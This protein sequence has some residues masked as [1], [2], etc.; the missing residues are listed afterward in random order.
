MSIGELRLLT[1]LEISALL[2]VPCG[3]WLCGQRKS[4]VAADSTTEVET[5]PPYRLGG[6]DLGMGLMLYALMEKWICDTVV[7]LFKIY[8]V[9]L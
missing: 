1:S 3:L 7:F 4:L 5:P 2:M 9:R 6:M 8:F